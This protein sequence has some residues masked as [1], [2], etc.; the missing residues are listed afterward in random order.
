[1]E[2][3]P[4]LSTATPFEEQEDSTKSVHGNSIYMYIPL[5]IE[6]CSIKWNHTYNFQTT[7]CK[8][9]GLFSNR[10]HFQTISHICEGMVC[11]KFMTVTLLST[12]TCHIRT[13]AAV[14][15]YQKQTWHIW[16]CQPLPQLLCAGMSHQE[17]AALARDEVVRYT[18]GIHTCYTIQCWWPTFRVA[19]LTMQDEPMDT[20]FP[21]VLNSTT[22]PAEIVALCQQEQC[23]CWILKE[24]SRSHKWTHPRST[25]DRRTVDTLS[26]ADAQIFLDWGNSSSER[27]IKTLTIVTESKWGLCISQ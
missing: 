1:M 14:V 24:W 18:I 5:G 27:N 13:R 9:L 20:L 25:T 26:N 12:R 11:I 2:V 4:N 19:Q 3:S 6:V 17:Y 8:I 16:Q 22:D 15:T 10:F 21:T 7:V 23:T